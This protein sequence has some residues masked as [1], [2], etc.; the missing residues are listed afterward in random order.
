[1]FPLPFYYNISSSPSV[2]QLRRAITCN[3]TLSYIYFCYRYV[4]KACFMLH[5]SFY[6]V[7]LTFNRTDFK[8]LA[9]LGSPA[10]LVHIVCSPILYFSV[11]Q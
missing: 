7:K 8:F 9:V 2:G 4:L 5:A 10:S 6:L 1:M 11:M 3:G